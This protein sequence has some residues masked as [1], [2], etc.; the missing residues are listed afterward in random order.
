MLGGRVVEG[1]CFNERPDRPAVAN[2]FSERSGLTPK[3]AGEVGAR[4]GAVGRVGDGAD[5]RVEARKRAQILGQLNAVSRRGLVRIGQGILDRDA[6]AAFQ[7]PGQGP[8]GSRAGSKITSPVAP[9]IKGSDPFFARDSNEIN[10][11]D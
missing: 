11:I 3:K 6:M 8:S 2:P 9:P 5:E 7:E 1:P 10:L 4:N